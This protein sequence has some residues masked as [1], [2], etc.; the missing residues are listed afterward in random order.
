M[1]GDEDDEDGG[2]QENR[3]L[4]RGNLDAF[5]KDEGDVSLSFRRRRGRR[6]GFLRDTGCCGGLK[7]R[8]RRR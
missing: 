7:K 1:G 5:R 3:G 8:R 6:G 4:W 2:R